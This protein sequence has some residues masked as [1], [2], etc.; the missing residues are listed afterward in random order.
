MLDKFGDTS[1]AMQVKNTFLELKP[2]KPTEGLFRWRTTPAGNT[3]DTEEPEKVDA[4]GERQTASWNSCPAVPLVERSLHHLQTGDFLDPADLARVASVV[5]PGEDTFQSPREDMAPAASPAVSGDGVGGSADHFHSP[6]EAGEASKPTL[7]SP[8]EAIAPLPPFNPGEPA[9]VTVKHTFI[10]FAPDKPSSL[11]RFA[12]TPSESKSNKLE[13]TLQDD[14]PAKLPAP[15]PLPLETFTTADG[16]EDAI[17]APAPPTGFLSGPTPSMGSNMGV[18]SGMPQGAGFGV[19]QCA[20]PFAPAPAMVDPSPVG[21]PPPPVPPPEAP[22]PAVEVAG[23][24]EL[25]AVPDRDAIRSVCQPNKL[26]CTD[27]S[28]NGWSRVQWAVEARKLDSKDKHAVSPPFMIDLPKHGPAAFRIQ[29][30]PRPTNQGRGGEGFKKAKGR[31]RIELKCESV[32]SQDVDEV[33]F[34]FGIGI[35]STQ[36]STRGPVSVNFVT[37][38]CGG[39]PK[40]EEEWEFASAID[41]TRTFLVFVEL[42]PPVRAATVGPE[43]TSEAA[44]SS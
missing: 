5:E 40:A 19:P 38:T 14:A 24:A 28:G 37:N 12:T 30:Y 43:E 18:Y 35:E 36:Q 15:P 32:L 3:E 9:A 20:P 25:P 6:R 13:D 26:T 7:D 41:D 4:V 34:R 2:E 11:F 1:S 8:V 42:A 16:F 39:L 23:D 10:H 27:A 22:P 29:L 44:G 31:G 33:T 21:P 17:E